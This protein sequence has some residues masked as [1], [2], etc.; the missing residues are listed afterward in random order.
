MKEHVWSQLYSRQYTSNVPDKVDDRRCPVENRED[1]RTCWEHC[2]KIGTVISLET[3]DLPLMDSALALES[4]GDDVSALVK[5]FSFF[6]LNIDS[7]A[8]GG[9]AQIF[10][11]SGGPHGNLL[12]QRSHNFKNSANFI[13][14]RLRSSLHFTFILRNFERKNCLC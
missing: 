12:H 3:S 13:F 8:C 14:G 5:Y 1:A 11:T 9:W 10:L 2:E 7:C 4:V 6:L